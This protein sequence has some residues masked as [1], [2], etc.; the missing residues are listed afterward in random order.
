[1]SIFVQSWTFSM[2]CSGLLQ[3]V[4][5]V[6]ILGSYEWQGNTLASA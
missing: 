6:I 3:D 2:Y 4:A 1:M 5:A